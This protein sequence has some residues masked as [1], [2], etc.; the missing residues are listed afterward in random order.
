MAGSLITIFRWSLLRTASVAFVL[1]WAFNPLGS[2]ASFRLAYLH[3]SVGFEHGIIT[4]VD[5]NIDKLPRNIMFDTRLGT[6]RF[7][8]TVQA[9][10][11]SAVYDVIS[12]IQN[13]DNTTSEYL[14]LISILGGQKSAGV[15]AAMDIWGNLRIPNID[16]LPGYDAKHPEE[17][18]EVPWRT[19]VQNYAS[20][21]GDVFEGVRRGRNGLTA[22]NLTSSYQ[23]LDVSGYALDHC[24]C[25]RSD[26]FQQ[27]SPWVVV[28]N[29]RELQW[30]KDTLNI[31]RNDAFNPRNVSI[32]GQFIFLATPPINS[33]CDTPPYHPPL[34][35]GT[36]VTR[37]VV[38]PTNATVS[39]P[40][41][42]TTRCSVSTSYVDAEV[43][44][45]TKSLGKA[46]CGVER[47]R[48]QLKPPTPIGSS[49]LDTCSYLPNGT[50]VYRSGL[51]QV[52]LNDAFMHLLNL[53]QTGG[54][55]PGIV[56]QYLHD[57]MTAFSGLTKDYGHI[58]KI[59]VK[60]VERRISL[61]YNTLW[62]ASWMHPAAVSGNLSLLRA[63]NIYD[64]RST[65]FLKSTS[66]T[67]YPLPPVYAINVPWMILYFISVGV[68]FAA[69]VAS[70]VFHAQCRAPTILGFAS[71]LLRDSKYFEDP[72]YHMNSTEDGSEKSKRLENVR[73]MVA[74]VRGGDVVGKVALAPAGLSRRVCVKRWY[75]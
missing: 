65:L 27:C 74:D 54:G 57:P 56:E 68:M 31:T 26:E 59:D 63:S 37:P 52:G 44:C 45:A 35:F 58:D 30:F 55:A 3:T 34:Y 47:I 43:K 24:T 64:D 7:R 41:L 32:P 20:L 16:Y 14:D 28:K 5:P 17:W 51:H 36:Y 2:Q 19:S 40:E 33:T 12:R 42:I 15:Q 38:N 6:N 70:L 71:S 22:F 10:Y 39:Y 25:V 11:A 4:T 75:E 69:A 67:T 8:P 49:L 9:L 18:L 50:A 62:K 66:L 60:I 48:R 53:A 21:I 29:D 1:L 23:S 73:V 61:L 72:M 46:E 13:V